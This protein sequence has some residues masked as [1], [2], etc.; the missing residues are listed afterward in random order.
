MK[1]SKTCL[2][3][4]SSTATTLSL[5]TELELT[6]LRYFLLHFHAAELILRITG[7]ARKAN[8]QK[9]QTEYE[10]FLKLLDSYDLLKRDD[11]K[12]YEQYQERPG[13]FSTASVTD[14]AARRQTKITRFREEKALKTKLEVGTLLY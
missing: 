2:L 9:A 8:L 7:G 14:A 12:L 10:Q 5:H 11:A 4:T 3:P 6:Q 1:R 13:T